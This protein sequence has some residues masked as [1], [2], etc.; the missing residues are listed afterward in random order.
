M[1]QVKIHGYTTYYELDDFTRPWTKPS[2]LLI[3][4]GMGRNAQ[5][6]R[7]WPPLLATN[8]RMVRR[9]LPG[10]GGS[11]DPGPNY[12]WTM[13]ALV[14]DF[15]AF[16]D[17]LQLKK[18]HFL[19][20]S[21]GGMLAVAVAAKHPERVKSLI[22]CAAPTTI[23]PDGQKLFS[24]GHKDWQTAL[25]EMGSRGWAEALSKTGGT[26]GDM[27]PAEREWS[28]DQVGRISVDCLVHYST[29]I[30]TTDVAPLLGKIAVPTLIL[31]PTHSAA[32]PLAVEQ[33][34]QKAIPN[35]ELVV[36]DGVGHEI[37]KDRAHE[38]IT[39]VSAFMS[40]ADRGA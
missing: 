18:I 16:L 37:Y 39:A 35:A 30:S 15:I 17:D 31:A 12:P 29:L 5:F 2:T 34:I 14:E 21:T 1:P 22:L 19:G 38:C 28:L 32:T 24:F 36:I 3:Q 27:T 23:G 10:H 40:R 33:D 25:R 13:D 11:T 4:H 7:H 8:W 26:M 6:W 20:E 9:D